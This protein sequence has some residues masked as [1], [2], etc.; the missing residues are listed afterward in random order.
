M[1][2]G[3][4]MFECLPVGDCRWKAI[5]HQRGRPPRTLP[6]FLPV[7][8][9]LTQMRAGGF[10]IADLACSMLVEVADA[11]AALRWGSALALAWLLQRPRQRF[12]IAAD[13]LLAWLA[14]LRAA[15]CTA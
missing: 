4:V 5:I 11:D 12:T 3:P 10:Y 1:V 9:S 13:E 14:A 8:G 7:A 6:H 15:T 2:D